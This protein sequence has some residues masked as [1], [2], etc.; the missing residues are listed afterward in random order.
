MKIIMKKNKPFVLYSVTDV[1]RLLGE[2]PN[3]MWQRTKG[4]RTNSIEAPAYRFKAR[5]YFTEQQWQKFL[6]EKDDEGQQSDQ[7]GGRQA[8]PS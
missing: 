6:A 5:K 7:D 2:S 4:L 8:E 3:S 1:A